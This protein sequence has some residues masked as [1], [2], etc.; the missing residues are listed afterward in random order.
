MYAP[1]SA[2][3][4]PSGSKPSRLEGNLLGIAYRRPLDSYRK[5]APPSTARGDSA[6]ER[7]IPGTPKRAQLQLTD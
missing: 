3:M 6:A 7:V 2:Y 1:D 5:R 4:E